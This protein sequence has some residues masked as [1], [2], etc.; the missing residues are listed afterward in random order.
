[1][2]SPKNGAFEPGCACPGCKL[3]CAEAA[4]LAPAKNAPDLPGKQSPDINIA[5]NQILS[6]TGVL[7]DSKAR[8]FILAKKKKKKDEEF[9]IDDTFQSKEFKQMVGVPYFRRKKK[10]VDVSDDG[11]SLDPEEAKAACDALC[12]DR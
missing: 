3:L 4:L 9:N 8:R 5:P 1:M 11:C 7:F 10:I 12:I 2:P 6:D